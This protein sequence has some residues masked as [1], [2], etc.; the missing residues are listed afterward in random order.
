MREQWKIQKEASQ[1]DGGMISTPSVPPMHGET[2][3][4]I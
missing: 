1:L 3:S 2:Q 4:E